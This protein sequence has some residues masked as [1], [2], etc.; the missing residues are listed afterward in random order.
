[1]AKE[2]NNNP[3]TPVQNE[4]AVIK[5]GQ[6]SNGNYFIL[7]QREKYNS[8]FGTLIQKGFLQTTSAPTVSEGDMVPASALNGLNIQWQQ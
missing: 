1:M 3:A 2:T 8:F 6:M 7:L 5:V 4:V